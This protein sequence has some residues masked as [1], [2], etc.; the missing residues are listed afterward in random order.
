MALQCGQWLIRNKYAQWRNYETPKFT[1]TK[2]KDRKFRLDKIGK[3][4]EYLYQKNED[5]LSVL[6]ARIAS[7]K[8]SYFR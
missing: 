3:Y 2:L 6:S 1:L 7:G 5:I 4:K 8:N